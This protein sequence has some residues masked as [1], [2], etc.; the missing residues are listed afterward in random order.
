MKSLGKVPII[1]SVRGGDGR[2][3]V[4]VETP[5]SLYG[6]GKKDG[7]GE[8]GAMLDEKEYFKRPPSGVPAVEQPL[9]IG[10]PPDAFLDKKLPRLI[11][12][13]NQPGASSDIGGTKTFEIWSD[14]LLQRYAYCIVDI[15]PPQWGSE[16]YIQFQEASP[17]GL[18]LGTF[19]YQTLVE[20]YLLSQHIKTVKLT[21]AGERAE[22]FWGSL[23]FHRIP[24]SN[25]MAKIISGGADEG[26][27][28]GGAKMTGE[29]YSGGAL[30]TAEDY[31]YSDLDIHRALG[32]K[33]PIHRYPDL[34]RMSS[35]DALFKN[36]NAAVLLFLTEGKDNGHWI[37]VIDHGSHYE[38]FDSFGT[39]IDGD[40][41]WLNKEK[42]LEFNETLPLLSNLLAKGN[43]PTTH[44][45]TK[46]Q[47]DDANTCG[48]WVV[49]RIRNS[50]KPLKTF[51]AEMNGSGK[52]PDQRVIEC[53]YGILNK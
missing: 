33:I 41:A 5:R 28:G 25:K 26:G 3:F 22:N 49:W 44:N 35:P 6:S 42:L 29:G 51:V 32:S 23:G 4:M 11:W 46:L 2:V 9:R 24:N 39:E 38:V 17:R 20:P 43:K 21:P 15:P 16:A 13:E 52:T 40:R 7:A 12:R 36:H 10:Q 34:M 30:K 27:G 1:S 14:D 8:E 53:T 48:R 18:G 31:A 47:S 37:G 45:S 50:N 19:L